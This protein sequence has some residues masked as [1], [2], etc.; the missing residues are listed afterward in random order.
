MKILHVIFCFPYDGA[1]TMLVDILNIQCKTCDVDLIIINNLYNNDLINSIDNKVKVHFLNR[2][3]GSI[4][5]FKIIEF[6]LKVLKIH[7]TVIHFHDHKGIQFALFKGRA[8]TFLTIHGLKSPITHLGKYDKIIAI[9]NAVR[10]DISLRSNFESVIIFNG[11]NF[12][13]VS[14]KTRYRTSDIFKI[15]DV[16]R[17][18][19]EIKGQD[20]LLKALHLLIY[21]KG[22]RNIHLDFVG[23]GP[24]LKY[25]T[26]LREQLKLGDFVTFLG[27]KERTFIYKNLIDYDCLIQPSLNEGFGLTIVEAMAAK[28]PVVVSNID[29]PIEIIDNGKFGHYFT[30]GNADSCADILEYMIKEFYNHDY[31]TFLDN[32]QDHAI[33]N[34]SIENTS[35]EYLEEYK[36]LVKAADK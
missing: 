28:V 24:S 10:N 17:L 25:L 33:K 21:Q 16:G 31:T 22:V 5:P 2:E 27:L 36:K 14:K 34:F 9:S 12:S 7:P 8:K 19:H 15:I 11:I 23:E 13:T 4:N 30:S 26:E 29:G 6:N 32:A 18:I 1:E 35:N 20:L 3:P